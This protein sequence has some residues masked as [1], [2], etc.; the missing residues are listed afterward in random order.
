MPLVKE[1]VTDL[2]PA[3][4]CVLIKYLTAEEQRKGIIVIPSG[5][6]MNGHKVGIIC[7]LGPGRITEQGMVFPVDY[8][9]GQKVIYR[10]SDKEHVSL[11]GA[12]YV[13]T[14]YG[15]IL[16]VLK[17][18]EVEVERPEPSVDATVIDLASERA[19]RGL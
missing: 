19:K 11:N 6:A 13:L 3:R 1:K 9:V 16:G 10:A 14:D 17:E 7:A 4:N 18:V 12:S 5:A 15:A 2:T 8:E